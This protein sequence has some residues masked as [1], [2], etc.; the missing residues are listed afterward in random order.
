MK[1]SVFNNNINGDSPFYHCSTSLS[2]MWSY[3]E[4]NQCNNN[5]MNNHINNHHV[6]YSK[7]AMD[8][9]NYQY[10][11]HSHHHHYTLNNNHGSY[12]DQ[13]HDYHDYH[14]TNGSIKCQKHD[15]NINNSHKSKIAKDPELDQHDNTNINESYYPFTINCC[16][17]SSLS[18]TSKQY[19][20]YGELGPI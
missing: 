10:L 16:I 9:G 2:T 12:D 13:Q 19:S 20:F 11:I 15:I 1:M 18:P 17:S 14:D 7:I 3:I 8:D 6:K 5:N 4:M